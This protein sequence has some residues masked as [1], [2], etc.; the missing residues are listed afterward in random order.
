MSLVG[1]R[2]ENCTAL[3]GVLEV[4]GRRHQEDFGRQK[5]VLAIE[6]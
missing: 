4:I 3:E 2:S 6:T 1:E 5:K